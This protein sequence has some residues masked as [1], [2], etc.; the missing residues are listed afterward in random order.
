LEFLGIE[1]DE[2]RNRINDPLIATDK[3]TV[4]VR[5]IHT[6]EEQMIAKIVMQTLNLTTE[7]N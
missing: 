4:A 3:A 1:I 7:K 6:D 2:E 5:I